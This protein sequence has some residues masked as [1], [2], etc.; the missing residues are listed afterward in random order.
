MSDAGYTQLL[1]DDAWQAGDLLAALEFLFA[2]ET[3]DELCTIMERSEASSLDAERQNQQDKRGEKKDR[4]TSLHRASAHS[5][6]QSYSVWRHRRMQALETEKKMIS[7]YAK[8]S[9]CSSHNE[10]PRAIWQGARP[11]T[12][13]RSCSESR[14]EKIIHRGDEAMLKQY[15]EDNKESLQQEAGKLRAEAR[16]R[17]IGTF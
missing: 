3:Q 5:I 17:R 2:K 16:A 9:S 7:K 10:K 15:M 8:T 12:L 11:I 14:K 13:A 4:V 1:F 6:L